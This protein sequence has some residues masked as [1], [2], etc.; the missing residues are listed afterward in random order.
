MFAL[1]SLQNS[2]DTIVSVDP[3]LNLPELPTGDTPEIKAARL[4]VA[5][6]R[7]RLLELA[8]DTGNFAAITRPGEEPTLF[9]LRH[10]HGELNFLE[11]ERRRGGMQYD[12]EFFELVAR[13]ALVRIGGAGIPGLDVEHDADRQGR[14]V[15]RLATIARLRSIGLDSGRPNIGH[16]IVG[17]LGEVAYMRAVRGVRPL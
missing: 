11:G 12:G 14:P 10:I 17:E 8:R 2:Y 6:E 3:A 9:H 15:V 13:Y 16:I 7:D 5:K 4:E 1:P